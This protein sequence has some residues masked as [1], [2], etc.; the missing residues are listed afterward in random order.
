MDFFASPGK[1]LKTP[2]L[3]AP[4]ETANLHHWTTHAILFLIFIMFL[5][6]EFELHTRIK[7]ISGKQWKLKLQY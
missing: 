3:L 1:R 5:E 7:H 6:Y 4:L 2:T